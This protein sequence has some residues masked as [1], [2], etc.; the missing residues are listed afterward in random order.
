MRRDESRAAVV[1]S[2]IANSIHAAVK[3]LEVL[4]L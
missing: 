4:E 1:Y 3:E 2:H